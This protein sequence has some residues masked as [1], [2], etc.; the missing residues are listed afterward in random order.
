MIVR[1]KVNRGFTVVPREPI[2]DERLSFEALGLLTF[3]L[4]R[5]DDWRVHLEQL[6]QRG[7]VGREK[8]QQM[9]RNL[10]DCGY[11]VRQQARDIATKQFGPFEYVV[12]DEPQVASS[13]EPET[14]KPATAKPTAY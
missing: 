10:I 9:I 13:G 14:A 7:G 5:P 8:I 3:L 12:Y 2:S 1:R 11:V 6:R 4:S